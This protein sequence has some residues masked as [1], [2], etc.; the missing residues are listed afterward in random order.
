MDEAIDSVLSPE[1]V[2]VARWGH[3][4]GQTVHFHVIRVFAWLAEAV[5]RDDALRHDIRYIVFDYST[6]RRW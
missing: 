1:H 2:Y 4:P 5:A 6:R 3:T